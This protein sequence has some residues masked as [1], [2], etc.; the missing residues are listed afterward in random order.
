MKRL[1]RDLA[2]LQSLR[3]VLDERRQRLGG[4]HPGQPRLFPRARHRLDKPSR[5]QHYAAHG[6]SLRRALFQERLEPPPT[7]LD[8]P[9]RIP[10]RLLAAHEHGIS[11]KRDA[12]LSSNGFTAR[13]GLDHEDPSATQQHVIEIEPF[14]WYVVKNMR[15]TRAQPIEPLRY[16]PLAVPTEP[17]IRDPLFGSE[18]LPATDPHSDHRHARVEPGLTRQMPPD[19]NPLH[20]RDQPEEDD[21]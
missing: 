7:G 13:L 14:G 15:T 19:G 21:E 17:Q 3:L 1:H 20:A 11:R 4:Q 10:I 12:R 8:L 2:L 5:K 9:H 6:K 16:R 18:E